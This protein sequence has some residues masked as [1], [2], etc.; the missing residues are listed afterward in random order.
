MACAVSLRH[1]L[2]TNSPVPKLWQKNLEK[3]KEKQS[4]WA[5]SY[6]LKN[7][8]NAKSFRFIA[9]PDNL[10]LCIMSTDMGGKCHTAASQFAEL[11]CWKG[12]ETLDCRRIKSPDQSIFVLKICPALNCS[13][14]FILHSL[15]ILLSYL[16]KLNLLLKASA[17]ALS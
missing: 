17:P 3:T 9:A 14:N 4:N 10:F 5:Y 13:C 1:S 12:E 7:K 6:C 2:Q 11:W 16:S 15:F 8:Q